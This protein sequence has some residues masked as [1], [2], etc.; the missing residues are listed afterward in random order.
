MPIAT[1]DEFIQARVAPD[2]R[3]IVQR[4]RVLLAELAPSA[5]EEISYGVP[6][7]RVRLII[8][9]ISP[10]KKDITLAFSHGASFEDKYKLLTGVGKKSKNLKFKDVSE[11]NKTQLRYYVKQALAFEKK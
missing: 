2:L 9:V 4:L 5:H 8:A 6:V 3:P 1:V 10:T 7:W 11:I